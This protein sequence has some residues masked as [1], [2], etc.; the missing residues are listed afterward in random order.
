MAL[1][2]AALSRT[3]QSITITKIG[4]LEKQ[5]N[6]FE[7]RKNEV[8]TNVENAG[9]DRRERASRLLKAVKEFHPSSEYESSIWNMHNYLHQSYYDP[10]IPITMLET[11]EKQLRSK[12]DAQSRRLNLADLY[13]RL[14]TE[15]LVSSASS[16]EGPTPAMEEMPDLEASFEVVERDRLQQLRDKFEAVIFTP[17][18]TDEVE[19]DNYLTDLFA[20]DTGT[21]GLERLRREVRGH[22]ED[23]F[24]KTDP[25]DQ[26]SI[27]WCIRGL[28]KE[29]LLREDK[30]VILQDFLQDEVALGEIC[31]VLNMKYKDLKNWSWDAG[32]GGMPVEPRRQLNGKYRV[33]MDE[34]V[35]QAMLVHYIGVTWSVALKR[36]LSSV[37]RYTSIWKHGMRVPQ[38]EMDKRRYYLGKHR[39]YQHSENSVAAHRQETYINDYFMTQ[40]PSSVYEGTGG[41]DGDEDDEDDTTSKSP[42]EIKQ[43][44][45]RQLATEI[46]LRRAL[47]GEV[48]IVQSDFQ[49]FCT[50]I[51]HSTIFA[52][53]RFMGVPEE[54]IVFFKKF[55]EAPLNM[56]PVSPE[57][58]STPRV[59][60][61][62]RGVPMAHA[63]EK[64][65][66]ELIL[67]F[68]DLAVAQEADMLLYRFHDDLWLVGEP[69]KCALA[70]KT[71]EE[72]SAVMGLEFNR[73][74]TGSVYLTRQEE[75]KDSE[76]AA[77]LPKGTVSVGFLKLDAKSG[78]WLINQEEVDAHIKQLHKQ[79]SSCTS[80]LSWVQTW[81]SCIGRFFSHT[82]GEPANC[83]G[84]KHV[85]SILN[86]HK[87]MQEIL[88]DGEDGNGKTV[89]EHVKYLI[90]KKFNVTDVPDAFIY[91][92]EQLGGLGL[93]N[94]F[95]TLFMVRDYLK[96]DP[97]EVMRKFIAEDLERYN[98]AKKEFEE[99]GEKSRRRR[100]LEIWPKD[101]E[102]VPDFPNND[103]DTFMSFSEYTKWRE[104]T[105][106]YLLLA[107]KELM[108]VPPKK[109]IKYTLEVENALKKLAVTQPE[110]AP[111]K[112]DAEQKWIVQFHSKELFERCDGLSIVDK[113]LLP[114]GIMI[115]LK[116]RKVTWQM[117]L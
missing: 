7:R 37:V 67:F 61:R 39:M 13:S 87:R 53:I 6:T 113:S 41:Y 48:A 57:S 104:S 44:L 30:R 91:M 11:I 90:A 19:I 110:L 70:W 116:T 60:I 49:W 15:W 27:K 4:E 81:N 9:N 1:P 73:K 107:Y 92:P 99:L 12:I 26:T 88:F 100:F 43:Q 33:M 68:M 97:R 93:R 21:R 20:T 84:E 77:M 54:W 85:N 14:L 55:L 72:F 109:E 8:L 24:K 105:N 106:K 115:M 75:A 86:T 52:V 65:F 83:F 71:M 69:E 10:S 42:K 66:G 40:L 23:A 22:G 35:L 36:T 58:S 56:G 3:L 16:D 103:R 38:E 76:I 114:L 102:T 117:V 96:K 80:V 98:E 17:L 94:P 46:H 31:D 59:Q 25:F 18:E 32:D 108:Q 95:S 79:L 112:L 5:R 78:D 89:T 63:L 111:D 34:D 45:L 47:D 50:S 82:F 2:S 101:L 51:S 28:L 62:K 64:F 74:K 29:D